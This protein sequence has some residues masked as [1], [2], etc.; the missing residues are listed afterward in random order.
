MKIILTEDEI[1]LRQTMSRLL[2]NFGNYVKECSNGL[3]TT[4]LDD[5]ESYDVL[6]TDIN[7]PKMNGH[8]LID[9]IDKNDINIPIIVISGNY[10]LS[11][12]SNKVKYIFRKPIN[13][14]D[15]INAL[16]NI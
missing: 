1:T 16:N 9:Y 14:E 4:D 15:L 11:F 6:L 3:E 8:Q 2:R 12:D 7:M 13:F 10:E 5:I